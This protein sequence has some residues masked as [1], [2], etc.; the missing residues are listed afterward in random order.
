MVLRRSNITLRE[1]LVR[2]KT[3]PLKDVPYGRS[4]LFYLPPDFNIYPTDSA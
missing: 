4:I 1:L 2:A 3:L